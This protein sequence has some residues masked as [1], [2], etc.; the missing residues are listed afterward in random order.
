[1]VRDNL[2]GRDRVT[3]GRQMPFCLF[4]DPELAH[5]GLSEREGRERGARYRLAKIPMADVLR[6]HTLSEPR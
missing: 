6:T 1:M 2:A 4:T 5:I 3:T